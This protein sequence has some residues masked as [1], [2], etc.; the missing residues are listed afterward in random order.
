MSYRSIESED[1]VTLVPTAPPTATVIW[2]HGLGADG[3]DFVPIVPQLRLPT[4][5]A[6]RFVFPHAPVRKVT[7]NNG[8]AMPAWYDIK[9]LSPGGRDDAAGLAESTA[10]VSELITRERAAGITAANVVVAGF[11]QGGAVALHTALTFPERLAGLLALSTY[12]PLAER[13]DGQLA[14]VNR[15][16]P[17]LMCHGRADSVVVPAM[18][19]KARDWLLARGFRLEWREYPMQHEVCGP[20]IS[21]VSA[22]LQQRWP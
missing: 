9:S 18:G 10:R 1:A 16:L 13:L 11:S 22:W 17:I 12:L 6:A 7:I 15:D 21:D 14:A 5:L 20:E 19:E 3:H 2:L 4:R 8:F